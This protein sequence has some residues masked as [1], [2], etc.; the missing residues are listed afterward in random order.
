M[1][2]SSNGKTIKLGGKV[3]TFR[4]RVRA[5]EAFEKQSGRNVLTGNVLENLGLQEIVTLAWA[6]LLHEDPELTRDEFGD[7]LG[8]RELH[9]LPALVAA[10]LQEDLPDPETKPQGEKK[11]PR[12]KRSP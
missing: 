10:A 7:M 6:G 1:P 2:P 11:S 12:K 8:L 4:F 3:R 9:Q 5:W